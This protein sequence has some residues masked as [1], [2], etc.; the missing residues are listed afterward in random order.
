MFPP[1][2][3]STLCHSGNKKLAETPFPLY[4][5]GVSRGAHYEPGLLVIDLA[6]QW[7][8]SL[9]KGIN[10]N[11]PDSLTK[12][13]RQIQCIQIQW[14]DGEDPE[15]ATLL[16]FSRVDPVEHVRRVYC[17]KAVETAA[18]ISYIERILNCRIRSKP[19]LWARKE[20]LW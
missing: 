5:G 9:V 18:Q 2:A 6:Y 15:L 16:G 11:L 13:I 3:D 19:A 8:P 12:T 1:L 10:I 7:A 14:P 20:M 17:R 4:G